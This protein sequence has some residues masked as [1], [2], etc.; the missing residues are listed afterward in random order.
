MSRPKALLVSAVAALTLISLVVMVATLLRVS[1]AENDRA[2]TPPGP[3]STTQPS[4]SPVEI[5]AP[6][7]DAVVVYE[8]VWEVVPG[9]VTPAGQPPAQPGGSAQ[10]VAITA[11][12]SRAVTPAPAVNAP[13]TVPTVAPSPTTRP[14]APTTT[15]APRPPGVPAD[16]PAGKPI[17]PMPEGCRQPQLEDDGVW[18]CQH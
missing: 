14:P 3:T 5:E 16:W 4:P 15:I 6:P 1:V 10:D 7:P 17:P 13:T 12:T 8:D 11:G 9:A 2:T 18:N